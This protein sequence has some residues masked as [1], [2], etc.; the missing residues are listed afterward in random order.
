MTWSAPKVAAISQRRGVASTAMSVPASMRAHDLEDEAADQALAEDD[1]DVAGFERG[2]VR[3]ADGGGA[4]HPVGGLVP[5]DVGGERQDLGQLGLALG[6]GGGQD[7]LRVGRDGADAV[8]DGQVLNA[9]AEG[10]DDAGHGV[11]HDLWI[12]GFLADVAPADFGAAADEAAHGLDADFAE[13]GFGDGGVFEDDVAAAWGLGHAL[14][15]WSPCK[16]LCV[17]L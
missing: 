13:S 10:V 14:H 11:A 15:G 5:G 1:D 4:E 9:L 7:E 12:D 6:N 3:P 17:I 8:A 16:D 2:N